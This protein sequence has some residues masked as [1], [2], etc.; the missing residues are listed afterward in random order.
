M[1]DANAPEGIDAARLEPWLAAHVE[2]S[3]LPFSYE[4]IV[5]GQSN[6]T[7]RVTDGAGKRY[8]L[9]RPPAL[10][11]LLATAHDVLREHRLMAALADTRV[12]VPRMLAF[13]DDPE[14][15]GAPFFVAEFVDGV[16]L[17]SPAKAG[18]MPEDAR[19]ELAFDLVDVLAAL[20]GVD[21]DAVRL[22][23]LARR[24]AYLERQLRRWSKQ[25]EGSKTRD[26][27]V[28]DEV[29]RRLGK[30]MPPQADATIVHGDYRFGNCIS[31]IPGRRIAAVLDWELCTLGDPLADVGYLA[32]YWHD[33]TLAVPMTN[34]PTSAGGFPSLDELLQRYAQLTGR[35][36]SNVGYYRAFAAF[37]LAIIAEG[38]VFRRLQAKQPDMQAIE[39][40]KL[41]V[42]R[43]AEAA[44][45]WLGA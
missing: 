27:P 13:T 5:G 23:D 16:V 19:R 33:P 18:A 41:G 26:L 3:K 4:L 15:N 17:D 34:D 7:F 12:P 35:D 8:V 6:L 29:V 39:A 22:G 24:D 1:A 43:L 36:V 32:L 38:I 11:H 25:W 28:V 44:L 2:G 31:D 21:V 14:V 30:G 45:G 10:A 9:R 37:R 42:Q 20:H 40:S